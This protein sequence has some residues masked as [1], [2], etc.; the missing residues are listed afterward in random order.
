MNGSWLELERAVSEDSRMMLLR[1][2]GEGLLCFDWEDLLVW[3][4]WRWDS[5]NQSHT[6]TETV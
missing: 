6:N 2:T 5:G 4:R 1:M 3:N